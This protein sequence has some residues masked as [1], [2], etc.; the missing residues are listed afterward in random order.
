MGVAFTGHRGL[1][2]CLLSII[3]PLFLHRDSAI[4]SHASFVTFPFGTLLGGRLTITSSELFVL[5]IDLYPEPLFSTGPSL[6]PAKDRTRLFASHRS[7]DHHE[8]LCRTVGG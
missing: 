3:F 6:Q 2:R 1:G 7:P 4:R 8:H 5:R